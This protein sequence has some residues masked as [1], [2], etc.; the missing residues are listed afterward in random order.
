MKKSTKV[1]Q[2]ASWSA[3]QKLKKGSS[4]FISPKNL[5]R[6]KNLPWQMW[7][8][9]LA[10]AGLGVFFLGTIIFLIL[11]AWYSR[12]LPDPNTL[13]LRE[14]A[15]STK[16][17]DRTGEHLLYEIS[18]DQRRT[19][20]TLAEMP[21]YI[22]KATLTA[23]DR[24]F[25]EH[26]GID[27]RGLLRAVVV[28]TV[29]MSRSQG[30]ST[31]TQ[32]LVKNAILTN[33]KSYSRKMKELILS[34]ALERRF[35]KDEILQMYL[36]E[37]PYGSMNYGIETASRSYF[38]KSAKDL[39]L[40]EAA[41]LAAL[42]QR[43]SV[44]LNN[45]DRLK[46]RRDW[47]LKSM[48]ELGHINKDQLET[49]LAEETPVS[50]RLTGI[51]APHFVLWVKENLVNQYGERTVEEGGLKV[52]TT[53]DL[54]KQTFA[55][56][57]VRENMEAR[58][59]QFGFNNTGLVAIDPKT[60][61]ILSMV[62]SADYFNNEIDG[63]VNVTIRPL[64]P[65]SSIKPLLY[66]AGFEI[67]LTPNTLLWDVN[68]NFQTITGPYSPRN[69]DLRERGPISIRASLQ[70]SLNIPA[71][72]VLYLVGVENGLNFL[73][74]LG[75]T[76]FADRSRFG[77][78]VVLG[79]GEVTMLEHASAF[80]AFANDGVKHGPVSV[81]RVESGKGELLF[82]HKKGE[83]ERVIEASIAR[84]TNNVMADD[85]ARAYIFGTGGP[86]TIPGRQ[87]ASKTGT[88]NDS[89]DAWTVGYTPN[90]VAVVWS[91]NTRG[92]V[93]ARG[94][95][96]ER[97]AAPV[98]NSFMRRSLAGM[99]NESFPAPQ[100]P[101]TGKPMLDGELPVQT[102]I[103]DAI[104]GKLATDLTPEIHRV[105]KTC[106]EYHNILHYVRRGDITGA[107]P[108][109]NQRDSA[110]ASWEAAVQDF[111]LRHNANLPADGKPYDACTLPTEYD[112]VHTIENI[113]SVSLITP[114]SGDSASGQLFVNWQA[115]APRGIS[116]V[117]IYIDD[118]FMGNGDYTGFKTIL[119]PAGASSGQR[120]LRV[121]VYDD[122]DNNNQASA[123]IQ[124]N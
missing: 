58:G 72:K 60:G 41:T 88:T 112:D 2:H 83:G 71:V 6:L 59:K 117:D 70:G 47:I 85:G 107:V 21:D 15:Q 114:V 52:I 69:F 113:P 105:E 122:V 9:F 23:E 124:I 17:Y 110:Y 116:R 109:E 38:N 25:Y 94:A 123:F 108:S 56:D 33:E 22:I 86:L 3:R 64:Q 65:G 79:G 73:E 46:I 12:D 111:I 34:L 80:S 14:I 84:M 13:T 119:I 101:I 96:G 40:A 16:I 74:R 7:L 8:K 75:Y 4:K 92:Q 11:F 78:A 31:I 1:S 68:T 42:P 115:S 63:K 106:G 89:K 61:E 28:N 93:M 29:T 55:E 44:F 121:V 53:L 27:F 30:A 49:A 77:L 20:I 100:I 48:E 98:W 39:S 82:E 43:P 36:N 54:D 19:L 67:G 57:A 97:V 35:S 18:G 118:V 104:S 90:L 50:L 95:G 37:I 32:Q 99:A 62:G 102:A 10:L 120:E 51:R 26:R 91:G 24:K 66:A 45:P 103:V 5:R 87:A 76:T 81:L